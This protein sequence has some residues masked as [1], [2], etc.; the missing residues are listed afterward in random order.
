[1]KLRCC[2]LLLTMI[3]SLEAAAARFDISDLDKFISTQNPK[4]LSEVV[5]QVPDF[6]RGNLTFQ[7][8][9]FSLQPAHLWFKD[10]SGVEFPRAIL[11]DTPGEFFM[12]FNG[13]VT[14]DGF[15]SLETLQF[16]RDGKSRQFKYSEIQVDP[17]AHGALQSCGECHGEPSRPIWPEYPTWKGAYG[18]VED[19]IQ[20]DEAA[21][22]AHFRA[23]AETNPLYSV[24]FPKEAWQNYPYKKDNDVHVTSESHAFKYRPNTRMSIHLNRLNAERIF[25]LISNQAAYK[26]D[27]AQLAYYFLGCANDNAGWSLLEKYGVSAR[28]VDMRYRYDDDRY[29]HLDFSDSYFDGASTFNE[30]MAAKVLDDLFP[31][32]PLLKENV[33]LRS[34]TR[35]YFSNYHKLLDREFMSIADEQGLWI[36]TPFPEWQAKVKKRPLPTPVET[37]AVLKLCAALMSEF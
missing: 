6:V 29:D 9:S 19:I 21:N 22:F 24:L 11:W 30:L 7:Y 12:T 13:D 2:F 32:H 4:T 20:P 27:R 14:E 33:I 16:L 15:G 1:M 26:K 28:D 17:R 25:A 3:F 35:T 37:K 31:D 36:R 5:A 10:H 34:I 18:S 23:S 8:E